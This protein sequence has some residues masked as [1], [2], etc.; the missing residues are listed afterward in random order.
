M[1]DHV[2]WPITRF[3][4][5]PL[6]HVDDVMRC[7]CSIFNYCSLVA[8]AATCGIFLLKSNDVQTRNLWE[9]HFLCAFTYIPSIALAWQNILSKY[10]ETKTVLL[11]F[12]LV[13]ILIFTKHNYHK[14]CINFSHVKSAHGQCRS[15]TGHDAMLDDMLTTSYKSL[16]FFYISFDFEV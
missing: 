1:I 7:L 10:K 4:G 13:N 16:N 9:D 8:R 14:L 11:I 2:R 6:N 5:H 3:V 15:T 12:W